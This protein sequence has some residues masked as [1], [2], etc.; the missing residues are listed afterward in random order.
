L[1][2]S[3]EVPLYARPMAITRERLTGD[4]E[5]EVAAITD[6]DLRGSVLALLTEPV[7]MSCAW[8]Y[9]LPGE[10]YPCWKVAEDQSRGVGIVRCEQGFGPR[11]PWGLVWLQEP[12]PTMGQDSGWFATFREAAADILDV[13]PASLNV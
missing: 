4:L 11:T 8:D 13:P 5:G 1:V 7:L 3:P 10:S 12:T 2:G 9:G 6:P